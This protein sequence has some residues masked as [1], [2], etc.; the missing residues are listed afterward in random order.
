MS[1]AL[2]SVKSV[3]AGFVHQEDNVGL[4][5]AHGTNFRAQ[6]FERFRQSISN[7]AAYNN[8]NYA[9]FQTLQ[10]EVVALLKNPHQSVVVALVKPLGEKYPWALRPLS[11]L[12]TT[13]MGED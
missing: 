10:I 4:K 9:D 3:S 2:A 6:E 8:I 13:V 12:F 5:P 11:V 1:C 7:I